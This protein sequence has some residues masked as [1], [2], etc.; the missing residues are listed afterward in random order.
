LFVYV[1]SGTTSGALQPVTRQDGRSCSKSETI[2][3]REVK[4]R[5]C[6]RRCINEL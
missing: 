3:F 2:V 5:W 1:I 6:V 4:D